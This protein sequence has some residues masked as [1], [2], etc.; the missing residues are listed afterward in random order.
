M[1]LRNL[2]KLQSGGDPIFFLFGPGL[3]ATISTTEPIL[4]ICVE[5][6]L[7]VIS[8]Q[9]RDINWLLGKN[10]CTNLI[11]SSDFAVR[12]STQTKCSGL[13]VSGWIVSMEGERGTSQVSF[14][15]PCFLV[16]ISKMKHKAN[17]GFLCKQSWCFCVNKCQS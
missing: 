1:W 7:H 15:L 17:C 4:L 9:H 11:E 16:I 3:K 14:P 12:V 5:I 6:K 10:K 2:S 13:S 8:H